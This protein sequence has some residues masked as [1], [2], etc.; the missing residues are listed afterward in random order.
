M[1]HL[2]ADT[3]RGKESC[4]FEYNPTWLTEHSGQAMPD[5]ELQL[6]QGRQFAPMDKAM[7]GLFA[8]SRPDRWGRLLMR[9]REA[10]AANREGRKPRQ[11]LESDYLLGVHD[12]ARMGALR[13]ALQPDGP[14]LSCGSEKA[15]P[16]GTRE[17]NLPGFS[18][19]FS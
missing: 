11:L 4:S 9:R 17:R 18:L 7:F 10:I 15:A 16:Q 19:P 2:Y 6:F 8:D 5:P 1:G 3:L 14:F 12:E 13:F